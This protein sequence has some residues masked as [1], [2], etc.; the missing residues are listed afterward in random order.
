M[1]CYA[2]RIL[3]NVVNQ[4]VLRCAYFANIYSHL[5]Y[6]IIFWGNSSHI[7]RTFRIQ[8]R[9]VRIICK[10]ASRAPCRP[11][12]RK[13]N[14]LTLPSM[15]IYEILLFV[16]QKLESRENIFLTNGQIHEYNTRNSNNLYQP[17]LSTSLFQNSTYNMGIKLFNVLPIHIKE[18]KSFNIFKKCLSNYLLE[19]CFYSIKEYKDFH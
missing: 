14:I 9:I 16:K 18:A 2:F 15:Y 13:L 5:R 3:V 10:S 7:L 11:L 4:N 8:K 17:P 12:F 19:H 1:Q 6:G